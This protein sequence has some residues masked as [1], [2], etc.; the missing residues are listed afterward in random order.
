MQNFLCQF[1][2][3][4]C[5]KPLSFN[6]YYSNR[7]AFY[8]CLSK[9]LSY[10]GQELHKW[11]EL[12]ISWHDYEITPRKQELF[13]SPLRCK[14]SHWTGLFLEYLFQ[15]IISVKLTFLKAWLR[16]T[17]SMIF[18]LPGSPRQFVKKSKFDLLFQIIA[19]TQRVYVNILI[20][21]SS[22]RSEAETSMS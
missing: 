6:A 17:S 4:F 3:H 12:N 11:W 2:V 15:L 16:H 19:N 9:Q 8:Q 5:A 13:L 21:Y 20:F 14:Y 1:K 7:S 18:K 22:Y 10:S